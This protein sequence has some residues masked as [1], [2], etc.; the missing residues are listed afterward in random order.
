[1]ADDFGGRHVVV[2][3]GTGAL[4][5]AVVAR[6]VAGGARVTVPVFDEGE[7]E[8]FNAGASG[9]GESEDVRTVV[10]VD[11]AEG[12]QVSRFYG[13]AVG[14]FGD[15]WGSVHLAGGFHFGAIADAG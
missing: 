14:G 13:E 15:L 6:L 5:T 9:V 4:G 11:L 7:L 1:M 2:T 12:A 8:R 10:G 3:G